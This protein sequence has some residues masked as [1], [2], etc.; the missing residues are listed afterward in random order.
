MGHGRNL[1]RN[2]NSAAVNSTASLVVSSVDA[3]TGAIIERVER[4]EFGVV[5][6]DTALGTVPFGFAGGF[7]DPDTGLVKFGAREY[8]ARSGRWMSRDPILFGG[9]QQNL[10]TYATGDPVNMI[11]FSG[12]EPIPADLRQQLQP[13]FPA[14][15]LSDVDVRLESPMV[16]S[17][18]NAKADGYRIDIAPGLNPFA[19]PGIETLAHELTHVQQYAQFNQGG[20]VQSIFGRDEFEAVRRANQHLPH[21]ERWYEVLAMQWARYVASDLARAQCGP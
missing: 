15:D 10:F 17:G 14:I 12:Q 3:S 20:W 7:Y 19:G 9:G 6:S 1:S 18:A 5:L 11:D 8:D 13:Y 4:D 21:N 2:G 16:P